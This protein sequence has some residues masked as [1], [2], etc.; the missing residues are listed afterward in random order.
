MDL[1]IE[2]RRQMEEHLGEEH[3]ARCARPLHALASSIAP[4]ASAR[5]SAPAP[6]HHHEGPSRQ[7]SITAAGLSAM[8][9]EHIEGTFENLFAVESPQY[10][11]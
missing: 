11:A 2:A 9:E 3:E 8:L 10:G 5:G 7:V 6:H 4:T 1:S